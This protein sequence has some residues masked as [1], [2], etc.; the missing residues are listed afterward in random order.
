M[1]EHTNNS[2]IIRSAEAVFLQ[3]GLTAEQAVNMFYRQV[4]QEQDLPFSLH[5]PNAETLNAMRE[6]REGGGHR[7]E[8]FSDMLND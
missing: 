1:M 5:Q 7:Y 3:H 4:S 8:S 2:A 6:L